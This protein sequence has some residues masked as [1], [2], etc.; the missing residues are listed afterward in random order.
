MP[1]YTLHRIQTA[2][3]TYEVE[4]NNPD[5]AIELAESGKAEETDYQNNFEWE[6]E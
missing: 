6:I 1:V 3:T 2:V 4:A 5:E